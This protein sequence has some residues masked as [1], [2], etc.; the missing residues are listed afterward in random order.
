LRKY[1]LVV[2]IFAILAACRTNEVSPLP[3]VESIHAELTDT[4]HVVLLGNVLDEGTSPVTSRGFCRALSADMKLSDT[5]ISVGTGKGEFACTM[6]LKSGKKYYVKPFAVNAS[7]TTYGSLITLSDPGKDIIALDG[8]SRTDGYNCKSVNP[9]LNF[10]QLRGSPVIYKTSAGGLTSADLIE[11]AEVFVDPFLSDIAHSNIL[12]VWIGVNDIA[13][14]HRSANSTYNN[15]R[16]YCIARKSK[17]WRLI[18]CTE[19]SMKGSTIY[20]Q[21][22]KVRNLYNNQIRSGWNEFADGIADLGANACIGSIGAYKNSLYFCDGTHL[23]DAGS[24]Q[25]AVVIS[26]AVNKLLKR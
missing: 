14:N 21:S 11:R 20:G 1:N 19:V 3:V 7:G 5:I 10:L 25:V 17:G 15:L 8:D 18:V 9:Y 23:T 26:Q 24:V 16:E 13:F 4:I 22:D 12:V 2:I 6:I